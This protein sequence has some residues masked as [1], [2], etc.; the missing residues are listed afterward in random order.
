MRPATARHQ[1]SCDG[2]LRHAPE[3]QF[4][5]MVPANGDRLT[6][7]ARPRSILNHQSIAIPQLSRESVC[8]LAMIRDG[9]ND[10]LSAPATRNSPEAKVCLAQPDR[11]DFQLRTGD[12]QLV[13]GNQ[14]GV[15]T[16]QLFELPAL[17]D[18]NPESGP[19]IS[20][21]ILQPRFGGVRQGIRYDE[22]E[23][24]RALC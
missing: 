11:R 7:L 19:P 6:R 22:Q 16:N 4:L 15:R 9:G 20:L 8:G 5:C 18:F 17:P 24:S 1:A 23:D 13:F 10:D 3:H 21:E 14:R 12:L 2:P